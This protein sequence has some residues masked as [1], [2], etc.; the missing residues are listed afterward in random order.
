LIITSTV[1][2]RFW[3]HDYKQKIGKRMA[4]LYESEPAPA[5]QSNHLL[6]LMEKLTQKPIL[7]LKDQRGIVRRSSAAATGLGGV[8]MIS[9]W[10]ESR[11]RLL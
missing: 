6:L 10:E 7:L 2:Q 9:Q 3:P 8:S 11:R 5:E 4:T 1:K